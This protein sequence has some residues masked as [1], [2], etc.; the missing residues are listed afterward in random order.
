MRIFEVYEIKIPSRFTYGPI[1]GIFTNFT[2][3][4]NFVRSLFTP[5]YDRYMVIIETE[6][7]DIWPAPSLWPHN[8]L[9]YYHQLNGEMVPEI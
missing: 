5:E 2:A 1:W 6:A 3:A 8:V 9:T 4:D 7:L